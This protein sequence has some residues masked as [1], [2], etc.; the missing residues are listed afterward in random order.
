MSAKVSPRPNTTIEQEVIIQLLAQGGLLLVTLLTQ[1]LLAYILLTEGRGAYAI[2]IMVGGMLGVLFTPGADRGAQY[3]LMAAKM[4]VSQSVAIAV[5]ICVV[6]SAVGALLTWP[7]IN[8]SG[9]TFFEQADA[10]SFYLALALIP[11]TALSLSLELQLAAF[12][13]FTRIA[14]YTLTRSAVMVVGIA[15]LTGRPLLSGLGIDLPAGSWIL[16]LGVDGALLAVIGG[17]LAEV[18]LYLRDLRKHCGLGLERPTRAGFKQV[19]SYGL[20]FHVARVVA[21]FDPRIGILMLGVVATQGEIGLFAAA[22]GIMFRVATIPNALG[23]SLLPRIAGEGNG[24]PALMALYLR[25]VSMVTGSALLV[26]LAVSQPGVRLFLSENF[27]PVVPL[28]WIMAPGIYAF[29]A[30]KIFETYFSGI[31][32]PQVCSWA[33]WIGLIGNVG[34]FFALYPQ[35]GLAGAAGAF[36]LGML[37][38]G[39]YLA[40]LFRRTSG[41]SL[42]RTWLLQSGDLAFIW[43]SGRVA[44][45]RMKG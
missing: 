4:S 39:A 44:L 36:T 6:G 25:L 29:A 38:R 41:L 27:L 35:W 21:A 17:H 1:S 20:R 40:V 34:A 28:V 26:L 24:Q 5:T 9:W 45:S 32:R 15:L 30:G 12:R 16:D 43:S 3:Y 23:L 2:C 37:L 42:G 18:L 11:L 14:I 33:L 31:N 13:R 10:S 8:L 19:L 22:S 7:L